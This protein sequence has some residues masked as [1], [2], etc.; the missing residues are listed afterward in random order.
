MFVKKLE[1]NPIS[2]YELLSK[3]CGT[4]APSISSLTATCFRHPLGTN[5]GNHEPAL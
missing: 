2:R 5:K 1:N 3:Y 4:G